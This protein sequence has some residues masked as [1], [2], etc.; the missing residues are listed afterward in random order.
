MEELMAEIN[1]IT[2]L[3]AQLQSQLGGITGGVEITGVPSDFS[4]E[5]TLKFEMVLPEVKYLQIVLNSDPQTRL[6]D[7]GVG[8]PGEETNIFGPL[9]KAA[10]IK[11][12]EKYASEVL[13]P[14]ELTQGTGLVGETTRAKLNQL[15]GK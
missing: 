13:A 1:R 3:I 8:S 5:N 15:L 2:A 12:Q 4:F 11:F 7:S 14:W 6:A 9:T 10:V